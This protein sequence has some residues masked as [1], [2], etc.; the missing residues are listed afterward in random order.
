MGA[1]VL[2]SVSSCPGDILAVDPAFDRA[3]QLGE[4]DVHLIDEPVM[5][6]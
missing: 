3:G 4:L 1:P 2:E 5:F 6:A